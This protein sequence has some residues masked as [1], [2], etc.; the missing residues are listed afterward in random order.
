M[1]DGPAIEEA[2]KKAIKECSQCINDVIFGGANFELAKIVEEYAFYTRQ[3]ILRY[4]DGSL[5]DR[6]IM[7]ARWAMNE[8]AGFY[9]MIR[10]YMDLI[11]LRARGNMRP[12]QVLTNTMYSQ[13]FDF[14]GSLDDG[15][16]GGVFEMTYTCMTQKD[17]PVFDAARKK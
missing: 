14:N 8:A 11:H 9:P 10:G 5:F 6:S 1:A 17:N 16:T 12:I 15:G 7:F 2:E 3:G 4:K 13:W